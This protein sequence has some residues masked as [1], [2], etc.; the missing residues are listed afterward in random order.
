MER[1]SVLVDVS[2][3]AVDSPIAGVEGVEPE[4]PV[5][6]LRT[7]VEE[8]V[9]QSRSDLVGREI[10]G[11]VLAAE[12][13]AG[14]GEKSSRCYIATHG[15]KSLSTADLI[16]ISVRVAGPSLTRAVLR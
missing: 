4:G 14:A 1:R 12:R 7:V 3:L 10:R 6:G 8:L 9:I 11:D 13:K 5:I 16:A 2:R 15:L